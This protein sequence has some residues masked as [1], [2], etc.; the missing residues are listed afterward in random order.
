[1]NSK[2][3]DLRSRLKQMKTSELIRQHEV[4]RVRK[5]DID[6]TLSVINAL[7]KE[8]GAYG[9]GPKNRKN[10]RRGRNVPADR[11]ATAD[12]PEESTRSLEAS[13]DPRG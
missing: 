10:A 7:L 9:D 12:Q 11:A 13:V 2:A 4:F 5:A 1:M 3:T 8:R 6:R